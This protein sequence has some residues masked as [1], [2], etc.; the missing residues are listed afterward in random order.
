MADSL[1]SLADMVKVNDV[2]VRD[3]GVTDIFNAAPVLMKLAV[4]TASHGT[5]HKYIKESA[6]PVVGFR[7]PNAGRAHGKSAD[8][9]VTINLSI[10]D[11]C[12]HQDAKLADSYPKGGASAFMA[13]ES[14]RHLRAAFKA[15]E[16]QIFYGTGSG[17]DGA[18]AGF[19]GLAD[20]AQLNAL[21][22]A[23][24]LNAN[25]DAGAG[26][27]ADVWLIRTGEADMELILG[28]D[29]NIDLKEFYKQQMQDGSGLWFPAYVQDIDGWMGCKIGGARSVGRIVNLDMRVNATTGILTDD[30]LDDAFELFPTDAKPN[31]IVMNERARKQLRQSR[32]ATRADGQKAPMPTEWEG[33]EIVVTDSLSYYNAKVA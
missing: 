10:L 3:L 13:R 1:I 31:L 8:T 21:A 19:V 25:G 29:G 18:A 2:S 12:H 9:N 11:A 4:D 32:T 6:A 27:W 24:V 22:D 17:V 14:R 7:A 28:Q 30:L 23:M 16:K 20:N 33:V 15:A 5:D 26:A